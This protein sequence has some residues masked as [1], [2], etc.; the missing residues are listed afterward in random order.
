MARI[1]L[2]DDEESVLHS[3]G[4]LLSS[5]NHDVVPIRDS[6]EGAELIKTEAYDLI[7]TDTVQWE[8]SGLPSGARYLSF[9]PVGCHLGLYVGRDHPAM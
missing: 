3:V 4:L 9:H 7:I 1:L 5:N 8:W 6:A 2:I